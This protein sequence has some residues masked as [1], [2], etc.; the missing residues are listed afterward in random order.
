MTLWEIDIHPVDGQ[1]D[2]LGSDVMSEAREL[3]ISDSLLV[4]A[5]HGFL[6][7]GDLDSHAAQTSAIRLLSDPIT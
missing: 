7:Q 2:L 3:G 1:P 5:A 4:E 6:I